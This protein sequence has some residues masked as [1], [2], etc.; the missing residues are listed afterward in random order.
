MRT[1]RGTETT[2]A[3]DSPSKHAS[4]SEGTPTRTRRT[5][6]NSEVDAD[7]DIKD[8]KPIIKAEQSAATSDT[9]SPASRRVQR[10]PR[11]GSPP[12]ELAVQSPRRQR[13]ISENRPAVENM[14]SNLKA[15]KNVVEKPIKEKSPMKSPARQR[16]DSTTESLASERSARK[17]RRPAGFDDYVHFDMHKGTRDRQSESQEDNVKIAEEMV[18]AFEAEVVVDDLEYSEEQTIETIEEISVSAAPVP[19]PPIPRGFPANQ[20]NI[21]D[22]ENRPGPSG[23]AQRAYRVPPPR[24]PNQA[25]MSSRPQQHPQIRA[26]PPRN[27]QPPPRVPRDATMFS[28]RP[29]EILVDMDVAMGESVD[30]VATSP[31]PKKAVVIN[32]RGPRDQLPEYSRTAAQS[33]SSQPPRAAPM[34]VAGPPRISAATFP[35]PPAGSQML[36]TSVGSKATARPPPTR[37]VPPRQ[38]QA[39][40]PPPRT[41][42]HTV[43]SQ[44]ASS[45]R[46]T[47]QRTTQGEE[48]E[49]KLIVEIN[50][51]PIILEKLVI[52]D[53]DGPREVYGMYTENGKLIGFG[54]L[55]D[56]GEFVQEIDLDDAGDA[57]QIV[58]DDMPVGDA[59]KADLKKER[60][61]GE[62]SAA[63]NAAE[64][65]ENGDNDEDEG[66]PCLEPEVAE[67]E[68]PPVPAADAHF[69][70]DLGYQVPGEMMGEDGFVEDDDMNYAEDDENAMGNENDVRTVEFNFLDKNNICCGLCGDIVPEELLMTEHLPN[71][72]PDVL[73][74][75]AQ[76]LEE[77]PYDTWLRDKILSEKRS[78]ES[79]FRTANP[80]A[81]YM[82]RTVKKISQVRVE[83]LGRRVPV[84]LV[85]KLHARCG[86]CGSIL[87]L[88]KKFEI[89]HL[90]RHFNAWHPTVHRCAGT[91]Q[92]KAPQPG[93]GKPLSLQDFAV[94]DA[95]MDAID[96]LQC[97]WCGMFMSKSSLAMHFHEVHA[98]DI[99]V[100]NCRLCIEELV[101]NA[102]LRETYMEDFEVTMPDEKHYECRKFNIKAKSEDKLN[103]AINKKLSQQAG[104]F[105]E[106]DEEEEE[107]E[108]AKPQ[109][110]SRMQ[111]GRRN[112]PKR[113]FVMPAYRQ[114]HPSPDSEF[115]EALTDTQWRCR[116]CGFIIMAAVMSA[117]AILHYKKCHPDEQEKLRYELC[118]V[119]LE[120]ISDGC[121]EFIHSQL[122]E[123]LMCHIS[124]ALHR[125]YNMCRAI[126]HL[127]KKHPEMMPETQ[128]GRQPGYSLANVEVPANQEK[129][130]R[131]PAEEED[132]DEGLLSEADISRLRMMTHEHFT[133][134]R[135]IGSDLV[136]LWHNGNIVG[137][138]SL[139]EVLRY[140][141]GGLQNDGPM[142]V[143]EYAAEEY[144][145]EEEV[146]SVD[147]MMKPSTS[148]EVIELDEAEYFDDPEAPVPHE[149]GALFRRLYE[150]AKYNE[151]QTNRR[152]RGAPPG[153]Q[154]RVVQ[155]AEDDYRVLEYFVP[156]GSYEM[157]VSQPKLQKNA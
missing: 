78:M 149:E 52:S 123:C 145:V 136:Q 14:E 109:M 27:S 20:R 59:L 47:P 88:N 76:D 143:E 96:G 71:V 137:Q 25:P 61:A 139:A 92:S 15:A 141:N 12:K 43:G 111:Y 36:Q 9:Q 157:L 148:E 114:T 42:P 154:R 26:P 17:R 37:P 29:G 19:L 16:N 101:V 31:V 7:V 113:T 41:R 65:A 58:E 82:S 100:P 118:K 24:K 70:E 147:E 83:K 51:Q 94:V 23:Q 135:I 2:G 40:S 18:E 10:T 80:Y 28:G 60:T 33:S 156:D 55:D 64:N 84:T 103:R 142:H 108:E 5:T 35:K 93:N 85:D 153:Y 22:L 128:Q 1:R 125:P 13:N 146:I 46:A 155:M 131:N 86:L 30:V 79:G 73:G 95:A 68:P 74:E 119:R 90:V 11:H 48:I 50:N 98:E 77:I 110:N 57:L 121:M 140:R 133:E 6:Q 56:A 134:I 112:K 63:A 49:E 87:S 91:W 132:E 3:P 130:H 8:V 129:L 102:R 104:E 151:L 21:P 34:L 72:H 45:S 107:D 53:D 38:E 75:G 117:G 126:R 54:D 124:F 138:H 32:K 144:A 120:H 69:D 115:V 127:Q 122:I 62:A 152:L 89:M 106:E 67:A 44:N 150:E 4:K 99:E 66:P 81:S 116:K 39:S 97:I 105:D